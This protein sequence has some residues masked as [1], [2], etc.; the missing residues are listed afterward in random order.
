MTIT[1]LQKQ[2]ILLAKTEPVKSSVIG[3]LVAEA[4]KLAKEAGEDPGE[5]HIQLA[6]KRQLKA[7]EKTIDTLKEHGQD[8]AP[9]EA[10]VVILK[11][12]LPQKMSEEALTIEV[13]KIIESLSEEERTM[14][15]KG[16][17]MGQLKKFGDTVDM[18]MAAKLLSQLLS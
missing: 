10:E 2:R 7:T 1:E 3:M 16:K 8:T 17:V 12:F 15:S 5:A 13:K 18:G 4:K 6:A 14:K 11:E 9:S